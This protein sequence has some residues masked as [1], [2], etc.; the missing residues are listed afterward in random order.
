M[1][2]FLGVTFMTFSAFM[3]FM[4]AEPQQPTFRARVD[5]VA[6]DVQ[7]VDRDGRPIT[8]LKP[9]QFE[10]FIDGRRRPVVSA[11]LLEYSTTTSRGAGPAT[12]FPNMPA[13]PLANP[14]RRLFVLAV[15]ETSF[16]V[17]NSLVAM[18]TA[19]R[20]IDKLRPDDFLGLYSYPVGGQQMDFT[21]DHAAVRK[22]L[23]LVVGR[24]DR[25]RTEYNLS[26]SE[27]IDITANDAFTFRRV[28]VRECRMNPN[29]ILESTPRGTCPDGIRTEA[30]IL[31]SYL[32]GVAAQSISGLR[33][34]LDMLAPIPDRKTIV[35]MSGGLIG[36][37][38]R[39]RPDVGSMTSRLGE[40]AAVAHANFYVLHQDDSFLDSFSA[41][42]RA[43]PDPASLMADRQAVGFGLELISNA[44]GGSLIR[45]EAGT[46]DYAFDRVLR[47][48]S[49]YYLLGVTSDDADRDGKPHY[50]RV[51][52]KGKGLTVRSRKQVLIPRR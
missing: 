18:K 51:N 28:I 13:S 29:T 2:V 50:L 32:E 38:S 23:E 25:P 11:S 5:L 12:P 27:I 21:T 35:V 44:V 46:A 47:E 30:K 52:V 24:S 15:D 19:Q 20:F 14:T 10:V 9:E 43:P 41:A 42:R 4:K 37:A 17:G 8:T 40:A 31:G 33:A 39:G 7:V 49:A 34:L 3:T 16:A 45:I 6:V 1:K 36:T 22:A 26:P 48:T